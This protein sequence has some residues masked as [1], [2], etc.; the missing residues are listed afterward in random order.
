M[1]KTIAGE[2]TTLLAT[3]STG[4]GLPVPL[5]LP[6]ALEARDHYSVSLP[7]SPPSAS[8]RFVRPAA[9]FVVL[10]ESV[11]SEKSGTGG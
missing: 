6:L 8:R 2:G 3:D 1:G 11:S 4:V 7:Y 9:A 5:I 10:V